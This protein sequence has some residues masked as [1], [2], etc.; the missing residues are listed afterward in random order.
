[1][2]SVNLGNN[3]VNVAS[4]AIATDIALK[5]F[6]NDGLAIVIGIMTFLILVWRDNTKTYCNTN[7]AKIAARYVR[8]YWHSVMHFIRC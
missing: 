3:L 6:G 5:I 7:A 8:Y 4:T 2:A 1:M